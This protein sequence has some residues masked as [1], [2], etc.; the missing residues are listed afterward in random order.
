MQ[1]ERRFRKQVDFVRALNELYG[2]DL[3][4]GTY[5]QWETG[6]AEISAIMLDRVAETLGLSIYTL[7]RGE[8]G[9]SGD[10]GTF[11]ERELLE[12][13]RMLEKRNGELE[14]KLTAMTD[15]LI[16]F[17]KRRDH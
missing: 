9:Q 10:D 6:R 3:K 12:R 2:T 16:S 7:L 14:R 11:T 4:Q 1:R 5:S 17:M 15:D 13:I 8:D